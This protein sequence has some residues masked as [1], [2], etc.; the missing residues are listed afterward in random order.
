MGL[1]GLDKISGAAKSEAG[2]A[3]EKWAN[4]RTFQLAQQQMQAQVKDHAITPPQSKGGTSGTLAK[5]TGTL[6]GR[7]QVKT[8]DDMHARIIDQY[9]DLYG[10]QTNSFKVPNIH[11]RPAWNFVKTAGFDAKLL[12][13]QKY[14]VAIS[15]CFNAGITFWK[16]GDQI[17]NY[18]Q[19]N[20]AST[21]S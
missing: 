13:P 14:K 12:I 6:L 3:L 16:N 20:S 8:V 18:S 2:A 10:Y 7:L 19:S 1:S 4:D 17:G 5:L 9:F 11:S 15:D 21:P